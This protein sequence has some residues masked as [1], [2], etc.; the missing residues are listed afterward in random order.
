MPR[1]L[2][3]DM[4]TALQAPILFP[5]VFVAATFGT[6]DHTTH[7]V[8]TTV[9][10]MWSGL[11]S[12]DWNGHTWIG[13]GSLL[14]FTTPEDSSNVEAKGITLTLSGLDPTLLPA[15][16]NDIIL[17]L[18]VT[19]YL[20]LYDS[21]NTL[22]DTPVIAWAGRMDQPTFDVSTTEVVLAINCENRLIDMNISV[23]RRYTTEDQQM[24]WPGDLG[25]QFVD[26]LQET[27]LFWGQYPNNTNN[28]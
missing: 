5:A 12:V 1:N 8:D 24:D 20:A 23:E 27:T 22:I 16:L 18:P 3:S 2:S 13:I 6:I 17:G 14:G 9:V 26:G 10:Y 19:V 15:A 28:V 7:L 25:F 21:T 11:G 4:L